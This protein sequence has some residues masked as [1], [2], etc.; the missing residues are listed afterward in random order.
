MKLEEICR[1]SKDK[2][3]PDVSLLTPTELYD[4]EPHLK[5]GAIAAL[6]IPGEGVLDS[7]LYG[8]LMA[9]HAR[10]NGAQVSH[11]KRCHTQSY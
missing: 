9:Q 5:P 4:K 2:G 7:C 8:L 11:W 6:W 3:I 1:V 10:K